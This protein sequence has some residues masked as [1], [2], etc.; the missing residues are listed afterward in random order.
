MIEACLGVTIETISST[1]H[2]P[3]LS[4]DIKQI[5][6]NKEESD[7]LFLMNIV[8]GGIY[9]NRVYP[10]IFM[11]D[12]GVG[13][14][15]R[16]I[17]FYQSVQKDIT[18]YENLNS[19]GMTQFA[20]GLRDLYYAT[21]NKIIISKEIQDWFIDFVDNF[22]CKAYITIRNLSV[23]PFP[24][25]T[26]KCVRYMK[27]DHINESVATLF[28]YNTHSYSSSSAQGI[29][30]DKLRSKINETCTHNKAWDT[31]VFCSTY[32]CEYFKM[33]SSSDSPRDYVPKPQPQVTDYYYQTF[34]DPTELLY[35]N[36]ENIIQL[37]IKPEIKLNDF[38]R[39]KEFDVL[40]FNSTQINELLELDHSGFYTKPFNRDQRGGTRFIFSSEKLASHLFEQLKDQFP[41]MIGVNHIF[42]YN[43]FEANDE[44]FKSHYDTPYFDGY[45]KICSEYTL[46]IYLTEGNN[47]ENGILELIKE[48]NNTQYR[49]DHVNTGSGIIFNQCYEHVGNPYYDGKK[50]FLRT[51]LLFKCNGTP[52]SSVA[53]K[54]FSTAVYMT[55]EQLFLPELSKYTTECY[56]HA[57]SLRYKNSNF[58]PETKLIHKEI[59]YTSR[60]IRFVTSGVNYWFGPKVSICEGALCTVIDYFNYYDKK[61]NIKS[62]ILKPDVDPFDCDLT[63]SKNNEND[64]GNEI[65]KGLE[66]LP[67]PTIEIGAIGECMMQH[68]TACCHYCNRYKKDVFMKN[69]LKFFLTK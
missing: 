11:K 66:R 46:L 64:L 55:K 10:L 51:E 9:T 2:I 15:Y 33:G 60:T 36:F 3:H 41:K 54:L 68:S 58:L 31:H 22:D 61:V 49:I 12:I 50:L 39:D 19:D 25:K 4:K 16:N 65:V 8:C 37:Q 56:N 24:T 34:I 27:K 21:N 69:K 30:T 14:E 59:D 29:I 18:L 40:R 45:N 6:K 26:Y 32:D 63:F 42:R 7:N 52:R 38:S 17:E 48:E 28:L 23:S 35:Y 44:R 67:R 57:A 5:L 20:I 62:C 53:A 13:T 1:Q 47:K 43:C